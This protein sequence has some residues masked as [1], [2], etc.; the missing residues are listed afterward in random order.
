MTIALIAFNLVALIALVALAALL[1]TRK[2]IRRQLRRSVVVHTV[3]GRS[4]SGVLTTEF[5]DALEL[6]NAEYLQG[7]EAAQ[8]AGTILFPRAKVLF[9]QVLPVPAE[10]A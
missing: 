1:V 3:D 9:I 2:G 7:T 6:T 4:I 10:S 5:S 8:L